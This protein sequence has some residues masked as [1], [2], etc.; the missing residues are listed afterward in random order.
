MDLMPGMS[1]FVR[2]KVVGVEA[3][4][5]VSSKWSATVPFIVKLD[6][7]I[8]HTGWIAPAAGATGVPQSPNFNWASVPG[9]TG[10]ELVIDGGAPIKLTD[11]VYTVTTP[12]A[13]GSTHTWKVRAIS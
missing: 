5:T 2:A 6:T 4:S 13:Y 3:D 11:P 7:I 9:A 10:Y 12:F 1:Y 8:D